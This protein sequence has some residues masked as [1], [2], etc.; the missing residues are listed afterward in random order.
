MLRWLGNPQVTV[1]GAPRAL[2]VTRPVALL[3]V[4]AS[5]PDGAT[6]ADLA[7]L[8]WPDAD[9]KGARTFA[10]VLLHRCRALPWVGDRLVAEG[11]RLR[12]DLPSDLAAFRAAVHRGDWAAAAARYGGPFL[13]GVAFP[14]AP[15]LDAW[16]R[17]QRDDLAATAL[18]AFR[19]HADAVA[20][21]GDVRAAAD[22]WARVLE[23]EPFDEDALRAH[24]GALVAAGAAAEARHAWRRTRDRWRTELDGA[25]SPDLEAH[26]RRLGLGDPASVPSR[27]EG[28][29]PAAALELDPERT[30]TPL[31]GRAVELAALRAALRDGAR[32]VSIVGMGGMGK[33]RLALE[34]SRT[35]GD[36]LADGTRVVRLAERAGEPEL[37]AGLEAAFGLE[38]G[39]GANRADALAVA[40]SGRTA[41]VVLDGLDAPDAVAGLLGRLRAAAPDVRWLAT[42]RARLRLADVVELDLAGLPAPVPD[43]PE[44]ALRSAPGVAVFVAA[45]RRVLPDLAPGPDDLRAIGRVVRAVGGLPLALELAAAWLQ[46]MPFERVALE[47]EGGGVQVLSDATGAV[48]ERHRSVRRVLEASWAQ[49]PP[50]RR[51]ALAAFGVF[52]GA[53]DV[54]AAEAVTGASAATWIGLVHASLL[55]SVG[56]GRLAMHDVVRHFVADRRSP[57]VDDRH[58]AYFL[59][60]LADEGR[61]LTEARQPEALERLD[62]ELADVE[63]AWR[64]ALRDVAVALAPEHVHALGH[65]AE[66]SGR[67]G[68]F[69]PW[70]EAA[71]SALEHVDGPSGAAGRLALE[72]PVLAWLG[73]LR[74]GVGQ[75]EASRAAATRAAELAAARGDPASAYVAHYQ[76]SVTA[77]A[78]GDLDLTESEAQA[79]LAA[80][81][82]AGDAYGA[83]VALLGLGNL[84]FYREGDLDAS[85]AFLRRAYALYERLGTPRGLASVA[86]N[87]GAN[88]HDR[89][90]AT[91]ARGWFERAA[92]Y[93]GRV[94]NLRLVAVATSNLGQLAMVAGDLT[95]ALRH[96]DVSID[97]RRDLGDA[98]GGALVRVKRASLHAARDEV[99]V[100]L[101]DLGAAIAAVRA[102]PDVGVLVTALGER[103]RLWLRMGRLDAA[104]AS[105]DEALAAVAAG[106]VL[107]DVL[108]ALT[109]AARVWAVEGAHDRARRAASAVATCTGATHVLRDGA[110]R[111]LAELGVDPLPA[112]PDPRALV[113]QLLAS[114]NG[115]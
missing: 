112:E 37:V 6:R 62:A 27:G 94:R 75:R 105:A 2:R 96:F 16:L 65:L 5:R 63:R 22:A 31:I 95:T 17:A 86:I 115:R 8:F 42:G 108:S 28:E 46:V 92:E 76:L 21:S 36:A 41:L 1:D 38:L 64:H 100:A 4:L 24:L 68:R 20:G 7:A 98:V 52:A 54:A 78:D 104:R 67:H 60:R 35:A 50:R 39:D 32:L 109:T 102:S 12:L 110:L 84:A 61:G 26:A 93:A 29:A 85:D 55:Q 74:H 53:T 111:V 107:E 99:D 33:S 51:E 48:P 77:L 13:D 30:V 23:I 58:A 87:L 69:L 101:L 34:V 73:Q 88:A 19:A 80:A 25:P 9:A 82:E 15:D 83:G 71:W 10:R 40:L 14:D 81:T 91:A 18:R 44:E 90:D 72:A 106:G 114:R 43:A 70:L 57:G 89:G 103:T 45:A 97:A 79:A 66:V 49:L 3:A 56:P 59:G 113:A 11:D 47:V